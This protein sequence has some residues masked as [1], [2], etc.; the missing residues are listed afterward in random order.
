MT[1]ERE[2]GKERQRTKDKKIN[3]TDRQI[4]IL[5]NYYFLI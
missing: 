5:C 4:K 3:Q 2:K 1:K